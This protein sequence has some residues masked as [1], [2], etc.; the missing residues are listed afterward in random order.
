MD[1][2]AITREWIW[3][4][5]CTFN[6]LIIFFH[7]RCIRWYQMLSCDVWLPYH[8]NIHLKNLRK[9]KTSCKNRTYIYVPLYRYHIPKLQIVVRY[10]HK[11]GKKKIQILRW[12]YVG[13][14]FALLAHPIPYSVTYYWEKCCDTWR[15]LV[16]LPPSKFTQVSFWK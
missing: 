7:V 5:R 3:E 14:Y 9:I 10:R 15:V 4:L 6:F 2:A 12:T 11:T 1:V 16:F 13:C 8:I